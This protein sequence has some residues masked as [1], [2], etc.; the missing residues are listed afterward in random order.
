MLGSRPRSLSARTVLGALAASGALALV[1]AFAGP[2]EA[3]TGLVPPVPQP[4]GVEA[5]ASYVG[6]DTCD[7]TAKPGVSRFAALV[8]ASYPGTGTSG[9]LNSCAAEGS[10]SEHTEGRAWDWTVSAANAGQVAQVNDLTGWLLATDA[11]GNQAANARR[12]GIMYIIWN[13]QILGLYN[14]SAGWQ[15]YSCSG[16]TGCHQDHVHF[17]F[18]WNGAMGRTSFWTGQVAAPDY[19]PCVGPGQM[20]ALPYA[21][22]NPNRCPSWR[23]LSPADPSVAVLRGA[24]GTTVGP[25]SS[26]PA[27]AALQQVLG[28]TVPDGSYGPATQDVVKTFQRRRGLPVTGTV[29]TPTWASLLAYATAGVALPPPPD[30][31]V[32]PTGRLAATAAGGVLSPG[33]FLV[34]GQYILLM[35][36]DGNAVVYGNGRALWST[37]TGGNPGA[38]LVVQSDGNTV[39]YGPTNQALWQTATAGAGAVLGLDTDGGLVLDAAAGRTWRNGAPGTDLAVPTTVLNPNQYLHSADRQY[40][41]VQQT[42]GN[43]V[44]YGYGRAV[45]SSATDGSGSSRL[46]LQSDGNVVVY[47][48]GGV[49][50]WHSHTFAA[51]PGATLIMQ[52]D[53]N[54]VLYTAG[55]PV[56]WTRV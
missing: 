11:A 50:M 2:A 6:A 37:G 56:W 38:R 19:G 52:N 28:G 27:V 47:T 41:A 22:P 12:L 46:V 24:T 4:A 32:P 30:A 54:L 8:Q 21:G 10:V 31:P 51:G 13:R 55:R 35:Q 23:P 16:V 42:D 40:T 18:A 15:P 48:A 43:F 36:G 7:Y 20:F 29:A 9:V 1:G 26:G 33:S 5:P 45:W 53:G 3:A 39:V 25:G 44:V 17:S 34:A 14:L 49:P